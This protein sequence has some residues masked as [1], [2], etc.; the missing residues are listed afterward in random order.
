MSASGLHG[1]LEGQGIKSPAAFD[2][3]VTSPFCPAF[4]SEAGQVAGAAALAAETRKHIANDKKCQRVGLG[5]PAVFPLLLRHTAI[6][7]KRQRR[8]FH[9]W[10]LIWPLT[11]HNRSYR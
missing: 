4:L 8:H 9:N 3:T 1:D 7:V 5:M 10:H 2:I 6:G 11:P